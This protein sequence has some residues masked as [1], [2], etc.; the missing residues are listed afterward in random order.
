MHANSEGIIY[1]RQRDLLLQFWANHI[2]TNFEA[3]VLHIKRHGVLVEFKNAPF[4]TIVYPSHPV[5][6]G[7]EITLRLT[8]INTDQAQAH[9]TV[10]QP[11]TLSHP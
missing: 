6:V 11:E 10:L 7:D 8:G 1:R 4:K 5:Q 9:F 3:T 2:G